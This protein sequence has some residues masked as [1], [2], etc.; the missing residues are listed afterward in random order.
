MTVRHIIADCL[1]IERRALP[2]VNGAKM[3]EY[4]RH[5]CPIVS[6]NGLECISLWRVAAALDMSEDDALRLVAERTGNMKPDCFGSDP[7]PAQVA[8]QKGGLN[9]NGVET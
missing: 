8:V 1:T 7:A 2:V 6:I 4:D 5:G 3:R 9:Q